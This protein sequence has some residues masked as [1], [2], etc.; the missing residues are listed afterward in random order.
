[1]RSEKNVQQTLVDQDSNGH[2]G[3]V[4][5]YA[6]RFRT[7]FAAP[8]LTPSGPLQK[9]GRCARGS[10]ST[11]PRTGWREEWERRECPEAFCWGSRAH[12]RYW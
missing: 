1:M 12:R 2:D 11:S 4:V 7:R 9:E 5:F 6:R 8:S 3:V 10:S